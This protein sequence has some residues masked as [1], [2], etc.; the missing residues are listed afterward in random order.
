MRFLLTAKAERFSRLFSRLFFCRNSNE[1]QCSTLAG[2]RNGSS[3]SGFFCYE[4][5]MSPTAVLKYYSVITREALF[6][7]FARGISLASLWKK[8]NNFLLQITGLGPPSP[9]SPWSD[10]GSVPYILRF[11]TLAGPEEYRS[12]YWGLS[13]K[14]VRYIEVPLYEETYCWTVKGTANLLLRR[15]TGSLVLGAPACGFNPSKHCRLQ[16]IPLLLLLL[17]LL[18][19]LLT[20]LMLLMLLLDSTD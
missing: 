20:V 15:G 12:W 18:P 17:L 6:G 9:C 2:T 19:I 11:V 16:Q 10:P 8:V 5:K 4:Q 13:S 1:S 14:G 3:A 7:N